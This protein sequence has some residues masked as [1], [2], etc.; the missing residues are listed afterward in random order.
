[1]K[2]AF[3][4]AYA[5]F[6][7]FLCVTAAAHD[8]PPDLTGADY[9]QILDSIESQRGAA[10]VTLS[11]SHVLA[12]G[13]RNL[14]W[15]ARINRAR[16]ADKQLSF[17]SA[18][19]A[20][21]YPVNKPLMYNAAT[22]ETCFDGVA[23][24]MPD[25]MRRVIL[26][27]APLTDALPTDE[28][29]YLALGR[30]VDRCYQL[31]AR[32]QL[33]APNLSELA[34][35]RPQDV[36]GYLFMEALANRDAKLAN[37][38]ALASNERAAIVNAVTQL[39]ANSGASPAACL[40][41]VQ[42]SAAS[43]GDL[44]AAFAQY[45]PWGAAVYARY[46]NIPP[47]APRSDL[48]W[49][50]G[51]T[52]VIPFADPGSVARK[53]FA[54]NIEDEWRR[55]SWRLKLGFRGYGPGVAHL[56]F[57]AGVTPHVDSL[58]GSEI[59]MDANAP[60]TEYDARWTIRHEFGHVLGFPD[61]YAEFYDPDAGYIVSYQIDLTDLMCSRQGHFKPRLEQELRRVYK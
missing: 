22:A 36:R 44:R 53:Q 51:N 56:S 15:L 17:S 3:I 35:R 42:S 60:L 38:N 43:P 10:P 6:G 11:L 9:R 37:V 30:S 32:W 54:L 55:A 16:P 58:G 41:Y 27:G 19:N 25:A 50:D 18:S 4:F 23:A 47:R 45:R 46:F 13:K 21:G 2:R 28:K 26:Q 8:F 1:M 40:T 39:C 12:A 29:A 48:R 31:A 14:D 20:G 57:V 5:S 7:L 59:T 61:C 24:T 49:A 52:L 33:M 34:S